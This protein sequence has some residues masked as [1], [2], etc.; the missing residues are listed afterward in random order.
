MYKGGSCAVK[1]R[2]VHDGEQQHRACQGA[3]L[4][5]GGCIQTSIDT[6]GAAHLDLDQVFTH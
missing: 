6:N 2:G 1:G 4:L 5:L 3:W